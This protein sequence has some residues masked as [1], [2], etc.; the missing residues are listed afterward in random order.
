MAR[1]ARWEF[2]VLLVP[3]VVNKRTMSKRN[4][5]VSSG[6]RTN[7]GAT[8]RFT[9]TCMVF[10]GLDIGGIGNL[11]D[12][13]KGRVEQGSVVQGREVVFL[14]THT[15]N[16]PCR[17]V[18]DYYG[19]HVY[20]QSIVK[21]RMEAGATPGKTTVFRV[22]GL[23][24]ANLPKPGDTMVYSDEMGT[25]DTV[26]VMATRIEYDVEAFVNKGWY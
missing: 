18:V 17:G 3:I 12:V 15:E 9:V 20:G 7:D 25:T 24:I 8:M 13:V 16:N 1:S 11:H 19:Y 26:D 14:P 2:V 23:S 5:S 22:D 10:E 21:R 4:D 6:G